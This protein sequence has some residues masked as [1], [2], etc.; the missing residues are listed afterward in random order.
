M[1]DSRLWVI[2]AINVG[3][4]IFAAGGGWVMLKQLRREVS[5]IW[6]NMKGQRKVNTKTLL[7]LQSLA[8]TGNPHPNKE[9]LGLCKEIASINGD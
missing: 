5:A 7:A 8:Q 3:G 1:D 9:A 6:A 2:L 4:L